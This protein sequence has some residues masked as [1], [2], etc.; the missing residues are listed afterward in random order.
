MIKFDMI[1]YEQIFTFLLKYSN[2]E[3]DELISIKKYA[4]ENSVPIVKDDVA[5]FLYILIKLIKPRKILEVGTAI[6][7]STILMSKASC[8][9]SDILSIEKEEDMYK[10]A[11]NNINKLNIENIRLEFGDAIEILKNIDEEFDFI[12]LDAS[13]SHYL[14]FYLNAKDKLKKNHV[15]VADNVLFKGLV[16][17][18]IDNI[19][20]RHRTI[21]NHMRK[22]INYVYNDERLNTIILPIGDGLLLSTK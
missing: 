18:D 21:H 13:K 11:L 2:I 16:C 19:P 12:F 3:D 5:K 1:D 8:Y 9:K 22:F 14:D 17:L 7:Y 20:R 15:L 6:A 4:I 10:T